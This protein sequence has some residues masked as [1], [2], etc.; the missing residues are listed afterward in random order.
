[1]AI[2]QSYTIAHGG[3]YELGNHIGKIGRVQIISITVNGKAIRYSDLTHRESGT[4]NR[5][6][7]EVGRSFDPLVGG[8]I[9]VNKDAHVIET[10]IASD[11]FYDSVVVTLDIYEAGES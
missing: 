3:R 2:R 10:F 6:Y 8:M 11:Q 9:M 4:P 5:Y 1:M 7:V